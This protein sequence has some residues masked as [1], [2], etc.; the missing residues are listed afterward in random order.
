M[1]IYEKNLNILTSVYDVDVVVGEVEVSLNYQK[2][3]I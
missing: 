1:K 3:Q 2:I